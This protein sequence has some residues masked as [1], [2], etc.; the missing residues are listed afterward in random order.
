MNET[1]DKASELAKRINA[2]QIELDQEKRNQRS[3]AIIEVKSLI[4]KF[5]LN[6][7]ELFRKTSIKRSASRS[8]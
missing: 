5:N 3:K 2:L 8:E 7:T 6:E 4:A 1:I